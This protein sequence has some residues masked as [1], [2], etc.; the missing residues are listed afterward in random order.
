MVYTCKW[1]VYS[2]VYT[3]NY[4]V[5]HKTFAGDGCF[6]VFVGSFGITK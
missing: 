2:A 1:G 5:K 4:C 3:V 6:L